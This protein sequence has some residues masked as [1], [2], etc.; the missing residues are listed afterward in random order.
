M[1]ADTVVVGAGIAGCAVARVLAE[2]GERVVVVERGGIG[3]GASG[4][5]G[6][7][8]FPQPAAWIRD[9]LAEAVAAYRE[10]QDE[11][12]IS[13]DLAP[14]P[15]LLL[16][17]EEEELAHA[18]AYAEAVGGEP[19]D[20]REDT[21]F[22]DDLAGG[23]AVE[24]GWTLDAMGATV[25]TA[26]AAKRAGAELRLGCEAKRLLVTGGR[27]SGLATDGGVIAC[28]RVVDAAGA[29]LRFLLRTAGVD[30]PVS[31]TRGWLLETGPV[32][33]PPRYA[34]EQA[35]WP[36]QAEMG[37]LSVDPTLGDVASGA[38]D[39][40][41]GLVFLLLGGRPAGHCLIGT[42]LR[43]SL[44]EESEGPETVHRLAERAVRV[45]PHLERVPVVAAWSGRRAMTPDGL[46]ICGPV[47]GVEGLEV[48]GGLS[49]IGM[50]TAPGLARRLADGDHGIFD[51][52]RLL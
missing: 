3:A 48:L 42:S 23:F 10:L 41:P 8:L 16:A 38:A 25:A 26:E 12:P 6:G 13:F 50:I 39:D 18:R 1:T 4:R 9:L 7:F 20:L 36:E 45:A 11:G 21:W 52:G 2:R 49:S 22:A 14:W 47:P 35:A 37:A 24:G 44:L 33:P 43:R 46:P 30:L 51:P 40:E 5:N 28:A 17:V 19:V 34:I 27:V 32:D 15:M 29:R 31:S